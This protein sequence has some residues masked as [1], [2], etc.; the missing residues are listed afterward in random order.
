MEFEEVPVARVPDLSIV[1][2]LLVA[3]VLWT[4]RRDTL[5]ALLAQ[6]PDTVILHLP[7]IWSSGLES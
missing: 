6:C 2:E 3:L 7:L 4:L 5:S 1:T